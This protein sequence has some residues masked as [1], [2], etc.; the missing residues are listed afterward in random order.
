MAGKPVLEVHADSGLGASGKPIEPAAK[1]GVAGDPLSF[2]MFLPMDQNGDGK[3]LESEWKG[4]RE[5]FYCLNL[6]G[7]NALTAQDFKAA[8]FEDMDRNGDGQITRLEWRKA[9]FTFD[10]LD[11]NTDGKISADEFSGRRKAAA[12]SVS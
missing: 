9:R 11:A 5:D 12:A 2:E 7:N 1:R 8:R 10:M 3:I 6:D 4:T